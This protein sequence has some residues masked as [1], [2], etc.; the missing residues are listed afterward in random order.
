M[1]LQ[2]CIGVPPVGSRDGAAARAPESCSVWTNVPLT[3]TFL[4]SG[5]CIIDKK[6][7]D[8]HVRCL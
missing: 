8:N 3:S 1:A 5:T 7:L 2:S 4:R 6:R